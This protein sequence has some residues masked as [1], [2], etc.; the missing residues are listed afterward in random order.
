MYDPNAINEIANWIVLVAALPF[1]AATLSYGVLAPWYRSLLG[2]TMFSLLASITAAL[3]FV[4]AR[5]LM[6]AFWGY[7]WFAIVIYSM[8]FLSALTFV[9]VFYVEFRRAGP[10]V[11]PIR[12]RDR[13]DH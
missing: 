5:R 10:L 2:S 12:R 11:F 3:G 6:G 4:F 7:E 1:A 13:K 9:T 8:L